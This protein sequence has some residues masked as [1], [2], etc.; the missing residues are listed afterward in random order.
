MADRAA[1]ALFLLSKEHAAVLMSLHPGNPPSRCSAMADK[2]PEGSPGSPAVANG[3][4]GGREL[5]WLERTP[6]KREVE[7]STPS[8]PT[9]AARFRREVDETDT[10]PTPP[11]GLGP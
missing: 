10:P 3:G 9:T 6:D 2:P 7:G 1:H 4:G 11:M 5:R 8:R